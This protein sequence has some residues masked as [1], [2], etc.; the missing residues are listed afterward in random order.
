MSSPKIEE[1]PTERGLIGNKYVLTIA[2]LL[3]AITI[4]NSW[5]L[6]RT[7]IVQGADLSLTTV[8]GEN[9]SLSSSRGKVVLINFM[10]TSCPICRSEML[11]LREVWD[12]YGGEVVM[13]SISVDPFSDTDD[14][15]R[16]Y[17]SSYGAN[18]MWARDVVG[19]TAIYRVSGTPTTFII[20]Q[21]GRIRYRHAGYTDASIF[22]DEID[23]LV[24]RN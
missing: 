14:L 10:A 7:Q 19:A 9:F 4:I 5:Y 12:A 21:E 16:S 11:E 22:L 2:I 3:L 17:A 20:D 8:S 15:L 1:K 6:N 24:N 13:I 18:W 23:G